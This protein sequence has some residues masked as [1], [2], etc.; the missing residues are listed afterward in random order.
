MGRS[1]LNVI[2]NIKDICI[3]L[4]LDAKIICER[5][6]VL[7]SMYRD[8]CWIT[9]GKA[10]DEKEEL[11]ELCTGSL[12]TAFS[13]LYEFAPKENR[14]EIKTRIKVLFE[15][16][17]FLRMVDMA[18]QKVAE[19]PDGGEVYADILK[20]CYLGIKIY[21]ESEMLALLDTERSTYYDK[22]RIAVT[23]FGIVMWVCILPE[24]KK[25]A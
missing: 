1:N 3:M 24:H 6:K 12:D 23:L 14:I 18:V 7:L 8:L 5:S 16:R 10:V 11:E 25:V 15:N 20:K 22:K 17:H 9:Q 21:K 13:Y 2:R 4:N 19:Y